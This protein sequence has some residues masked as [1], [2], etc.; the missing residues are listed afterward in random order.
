M[1]YLVLDTNVLLLDHNNLLA[2]GSVPDTTIVLAETV[3]EEMDAKKHGLNELA[4]QSRSFGR[5]LSKAD[6]LKVEQT[7]IAT[8][9]TLKLFGIN[10]IVV[11][12]QKYDIDTSK[13][14]KNDQKIIEVAKYS[15]RVLGATTLMSNDVMMRLRAIA[16]GLIVADFKEVDKVDYEF[17]K[18][19]EVTDDTFRNLHGKNIMEIDPDHKVEH[20][21][22]KFT[23][24]L[25]AQ[26]KIASINN[27]TINI[28]GK[29]TEAELRK[30]SVNPSNADQLLLSRAILDPAMDL[31]V[32]EALAGSGKTLVSL[33]NAMR[34]VKSNS[35]I[36]RAHV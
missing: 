25:S 12:L 26:M 1:N 18:T 13:D 9:S 23:T 10:I 8:E 4:F 11:T 20:Y 6:V 16:D 15:K 33:S 14:S 30:Q 2:L 17:T 28:L 3:L 21:N 36:G 34:L 32:C 35:Q 5:L 31:I 22:Y 7:D 24:P 19:L 27:E 29:E